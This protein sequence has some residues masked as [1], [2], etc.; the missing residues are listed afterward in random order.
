MMP[1]TTC[2]SKPG[3]RVIKAFNSSTVNCLAYKTNTKHV[4]F[5]YCMDIINE[6]LLGD[7]LC[8]SKLQVLF[9]KESLCALFS[10]RVLTYDAHFY[11]YYRGVNYAALCIYGMDFG[12]NKCLKI[13]L[14][15]SCSS[16]HGIIDHN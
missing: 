5:T 3:I 11:Y 9:Y 13:I 6:N 4:L 8:S 12:V 7:W 10:Y 14:I 15:S 2:S 16:H 1:L